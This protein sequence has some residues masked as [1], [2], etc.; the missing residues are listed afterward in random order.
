M[1]ALKGGNRSFLKIL[2]A[3]RDRQFIPLIQ[4]AKGHGVPILVEPREQLDRLVPEGHH[5]GV[6]GIVAA[7]AYAHEEAV[8]AFAENQTNHPFLLAFDGVEDPQNLGAAIRTAE[9]AGV[10]GIFIPERRAVGLTASVAR[11]SAG[12][13]E[14][15][16]IARTVNIGKLVERMKKKGIVPIALDPR[17]KDLYTDCNFRQPVLLVFGS[18]G[19]GLRPGVGDKCEHRVR[20]P[21]QGKI[22]SLNVSASVAVVTFEVVRQREYKGGNGGSL[23][24]LDETFLNSG[25]Q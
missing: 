17:A 11:A 5:Q 1:E 23:P 15:I 13:L 24:N 10:H 12:A 8:L 2:V 21:V 7:K 22:Q 25:V 3:H 18:E 9:V 14:H 4:L 16:Q 20:I 6:V 19:K